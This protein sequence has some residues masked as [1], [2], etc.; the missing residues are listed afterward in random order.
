[1]VGCPGFVGGRQGRE[2]TLW[3]PT[4]PLWRVNARAWGR[5]WVFELFAPAL[6]VCAEC[7]KSPQALSICTSA[8]G[9]KLGTGVLPGRL[10]SSETAARMQTALITV[11]AWP[12]NNAM[13]VSPG[14]AARHCF[15]CF[16][17][18]RSTARPQGPLPPFQGLH[19]TRDIDQS[20]GLLSLLT[21]DSHCPDGAS[22]K[23][24]VSTASHPFVGGKTKAQRGQA[25]CSELQS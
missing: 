19:P 9:Y 24:I 6:W 7:S 17:A 3:R 13:L 22:G 16:P 5:V 20:R 2:L 11:V 18:T 25:T 10:G 21:T 8:S 1:M 15:S 12:V 4:G 14:R 23:R